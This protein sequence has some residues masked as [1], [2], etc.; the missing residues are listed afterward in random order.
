[1]TTPEPVSPIQRYLAAFKDTWTDQTPSEQVRFVALDTETTGLDPRTDRLITIGA[2]A[3]KGGEIL[4]DDAF[5]AMLKVAYNS[6]SVTVHGITRDEARE[7]T[8]EVEALEAF[9]G[10]LRDGVIVGHHIGHDVEML[11]RAGERHFGIRML[12]RSLDTMDLTLHLKDDGAILP[13]SEITN[14][15][16]DGLCE[17]FGVEPHDRHTAGGDAFI[18]AQIFL[19]LLRIGR[20]SGRATLGRLA[21]SYPTS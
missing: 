12:N 16:L 19:R 10:Y 15:S 7:G 2:V 21:E 20:K 18:T 4:L 13:Q 9:L 14:F 3:V 11:N 5:E 17:W 1:M 6:S 8:D